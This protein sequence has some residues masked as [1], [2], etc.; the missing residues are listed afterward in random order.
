AVAPDAAIGGWAEG[1]LILFENVP[2]AGIRRS[3]LQ[4]GN[5][6]CIAFGPGGKLLAVGGEDKEVHL[7]DLTAAARKKIGA[8]SGLHNPPAKLSF[9][10]DGSA[11]AA[12]DADG[13]TFRVWDLARHHPR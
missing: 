12:V 9:A 5:A 8:L 7:W 1:L 6:R 11:L 3:T 13:T 4:V 2:N 10:A